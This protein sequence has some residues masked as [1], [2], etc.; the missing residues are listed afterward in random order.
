MKGHLL[1]VM[2]R[3]QVVEMMYIA[4]SGKVSK[5]RVKILKITED[6]FSAYC[7]L[8]H[9]KRTFKI[10]NVLALAPVIS[11]VREVI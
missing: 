10:D 4:K 11:K 7:F 9:A 1:K 2:Q 6:S 8:K 3:N 5:R